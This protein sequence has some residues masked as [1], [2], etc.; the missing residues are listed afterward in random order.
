[1]MKLDKNVLK[2]EL[3]AR[4]LTRQARKFQKNIQELVIN[5]RLPL[6]L[7]PRGQ[8]ERSLRYL[9]HKIPPGDMLGI[10]NIKGL[11]DSPAML[12]LKDD[13]HFIAILVPT[14]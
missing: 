9:S 11:L 13:H 7:V 10:S 5:N 14:F 12:L 3:K 4:H 1:M 6:G 2:L 8:L